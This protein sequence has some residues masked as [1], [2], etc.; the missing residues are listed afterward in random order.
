MSVNLGVHLECNTLFCAFSF[1]LSRRGGNPKPS[2]SLSAILGRRILRVAASH[3]LDIAMLRKAAV[4]T[5]SLNIYLVVT[6]IAC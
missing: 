5:R 4:A 6:S 2:K 1:S 3:M